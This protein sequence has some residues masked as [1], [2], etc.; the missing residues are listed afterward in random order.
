MIF[1]IFDMPNCT[2]LS[3]QGKLEY[4]VQLRTLL[5]L[6]QLS[7]F[8]L[9]I[10]ELNDLTSIFVV[11]SNPTWEGVQILWIGGGRL[12]PKDEP[13]ILIIERVMVLF[14]TQPEAKIPPLQ[15]TESGPPPR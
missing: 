8:T 6:L 14:V 15:S 7:I 13:S 4:K 2:I 11:N 5:K 9:H 3:S 1:N 10:V 12:N